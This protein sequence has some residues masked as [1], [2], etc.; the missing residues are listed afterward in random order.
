[1]KEN[2]D[3]LAF[4]TDEIKMCILIFIL[5]KLSFDERL[6]DVLVAVGDF[7]IFP[8]IQLL[9]DVLEAILA[10]LIDAEP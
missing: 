9:L 2:D 6:N 3:T 5:R 7:E 4:V 8:R 1:M 10:G